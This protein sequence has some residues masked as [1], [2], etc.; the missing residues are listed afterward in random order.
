[1]A[2]KLRAVAAREASRD[3]VTGRFGNQE[4]S[5]PGTPLTDPGVDETRPGDRVYEIPEA[6]VAG[7]EGQVDAANRRLERAGVSERFEIIDDGTDVRVDE[8]TGAAT[9]VHLLRLDRPE[10]SSGPWSFQTVSTRAENGRAT[11]W[12]SSVA[13]VEGLP[14]VESFDCDHCH[15]KSHRGKIY[16]VRNRETGE[17]MQ[18]GSSCLELY[19]GVRPK[20]LWALEYNPD[21]P[22]REGEM[23]GEGEPRGWSSPSSVVDARDTLLASIRAIGMADGMYV[24]KSMASFELPSTSTRVREDFD[25]LLQEPPTEAEE[26]EIDETLEYA[27]SLEDSNDECLQNVH[28]VLTPAEGHQSWVGARHVG[29]AA[30]AVAALRREEREQARREERAQLA[31]RKKPEYLAPAGTKLKDLGPVKAEVLQVNTSRSYYGYQEKTTYH[32]QMLDED[33]HVLYW[34]S[35]NPPAADAGDRVTLTGGT[36]KDTRVSDY[37]GDHETVLTRVKLEP[38]AG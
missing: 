36:V 32:V 6:L 8:E 26:R 18:L 13:D 2:I 3:Q 9:R 7:F 29:V 5:T 12:C 21:V 35:S 22:V 28:R 15:R 20:G 19:T 14:E 34:R 33:G 23:F 25:Q 11:V 38:D 10:I 37:S 16:Q 4:H 24:S 30:S 17:L 1:M 31:K 27:E